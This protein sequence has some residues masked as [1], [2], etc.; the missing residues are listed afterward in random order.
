MQGEIRLQDGADDRQGR[1]EL[2]NNNAWGT[3]CD[4]FFGAEEAT[5]ACRQLGLNGDG[6]WREEAML[7]CSS[8]L[9]LQICHRCNGTVICLLR[10]GNRRDCVGQCSVYWNRDLSVRLHPQR[11]RISQ[12]R[13]L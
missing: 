9:I 1:V 8:E 10:T 13:A 6:E 7:V 11:Y 3:V 2:C 4:D 12:L 5:V